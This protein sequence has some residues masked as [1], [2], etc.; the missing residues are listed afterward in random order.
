MIT[1][2]KYSHLI[3]HVYEAISGSL[4]ASAQ[5]CL[6]SMSTYIVMQMRKANH[7]RQL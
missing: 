2:T 4:V 3:Q 5:N 6:T 7:E 1:Y